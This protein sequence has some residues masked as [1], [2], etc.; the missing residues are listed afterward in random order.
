MFHQRV[1]RSFA[2]LLAGPAVAASS[3]AVASSATRLEAPEE[4]ST[5][6]APAGP[7]VEFV[8]VFVDKDSAAKLRAQ[9]PSKFP[10]SGNSASD[11]QL[12]LVLKYNPTDKEKETFAPILGRAT[13]LHVKGYVEDAQTQAVLVAVTTE[14]GEPID[15]DTGTDFPHVTVASVN[16]QQGLNSGYTSVLL[17]RLRASG[18]LDAL[19]ANETT[20]E[21]SGELPAFES[22]LLPLFNPFPAMPASVAPPAQND[23]VLTGTLCVSSSFDPES[24]TCLAPKAEC[25]FCKFM[26][27]GPC[28]VQFTAWEAC[29]DR[30]KKSGL[31]FIDH[32]GVETLALR[33][34]VDAN[35]DYY[36]VLNEPPEGEEEGEEKKEEAASKTEEAK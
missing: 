29:L 31:D 21:W 5:S 16:G 9:Y 11:H 10:S 25:G 22:A 8:G 19:L 1:R 34:C 6:S 30:C 7:G 24:G 20:S 26:K 4:P 27:A 32:C 36:S 13:Q 35:P 33:D 17:E 12:F 3:L 28:G 15:F 2:S 14:S 18:Q 23:N